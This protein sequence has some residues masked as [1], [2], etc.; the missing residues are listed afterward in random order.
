MNGLYG[1]LGRHDAPDSLHRLLAPILHPDNLGLL[2]ST[3]TQYGVG[4]RDAFS[5]SVLLARDGFII[6]LHGRPLFK[7]ADFAR[8]AREHTPAEALWIAWRDESSEALRHLGGSFALAVL[9]PAADKAWLAI[10]PMGIERLCFAAAKDQLAFSTSAHV[11]ASHP[12]VGRHVDLQS[13]YDFFYFHVLPSPGTI[14]QKVEKL[15]PG[16][17]LSYDRGT[18]TRRFYWAMD[19]TPEGD[20]DFAAFR[21]DFRVHLTTGVKHSLDRSRAGAFLS[22]GTDSSTVVGTLTAV[23][24]HPAETFSIGFDAEGFDEMEYARIAARRFASHSH[25]YY[26]KPA[27]IVSAIPVITAQY[28]EPF[29]N[30]SAVPAYFCARLAR[31]HGIEVMLAGDGGDEIFGGNARYAKQKVFEAYFHLPALLRQALIEPLAHVPGL[32]DHLPLRKLKSYVDQANVRL[33]DRLEAYNFLHRSPLSDIFEQDFLAAVD[34]SATT[35]QLRAVYERTNHA[36]P[37]KRMMHIDLKFTLA[38]NDLRKVV[39]MC[40]A[41][42]IE[43]RFPLL[44]EGLVSFSGHLPSEYLVKGLKLRWFFKEALRDLLPEQII[45]KTKHGFGL[46]FGPWS[47][48]HGPLRELVG[49]SLSALTRRGWVRRAYLDHILHHQQNTHASYYGIMIWVAMILEQWLEAHHQ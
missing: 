31:E 15:L 42:G 19:Y 27:D 37:V 7:R 9:Q 4:L 30:D 18:V 13:I 38:D 23:Q 41:A 47:V 45:N 5:R 43:A 1:W 17:V 10:D 44:D 36:D 14:Y 26:L 35:R 20:R 3:G 8:L 48:S 34:P 29:G 39:T 46:P 40:E 16:E 6:A 12:A 33:P 49:D 24:G 2:Q 21:K 32:S 28:D 25:E 22:G 11:V